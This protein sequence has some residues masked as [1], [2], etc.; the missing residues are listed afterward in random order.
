[1]TRPFR[2]FMDEV[3]VWNRARTPTEIRESFTRR[4]TGYEP[5]L[6]TYHTFEEPEGDLVFNHAVQ[7]ASE[8][9]IAV[10]R[11]EGEEVWRVGLPVS[12]A[13]SP[14]FWEFGTRVVSRRLF[15]NQSAF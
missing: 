14:I 12:R 5:G 13:A 1:P 4:L 9:S 7:G 6:L 11:V 2:G 10:P 8:A 15:Y 3:R